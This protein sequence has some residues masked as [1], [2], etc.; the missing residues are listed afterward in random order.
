MPTNSKTDIRT[1]IQSDIQSETHHAL[2]ALDWVGMGQMESAIRID[3]I[4]IPCSIS[5]V[6]NLREGNRGIHMSRLYALMMEQFLNKD[7]SKISLQNFLKTA[8]TS[9]E[10]LSDQAGLEMKFKLP[11]KTKALKSGSSSLTPLTLD[12]NSTICVAP[13]KYDSLLSSICV[14]RSTKQTFKDA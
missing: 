11:V 4:H 6:V 2:Q 10:G 12:F 7:L 9:Q 13:S 3:D 1:N 5:M 8:I 14:A